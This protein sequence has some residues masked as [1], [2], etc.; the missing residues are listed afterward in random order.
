M[1]P[2]AVDMLR[3]TQA[4]AGHAWSSA[5]S[6]QISIGVAVAGFAL[7]ALGLWLIFR[8]LKVSEAAANAASEATRIA[9]SDMRPWLTL[10]ADH[11]EQAFIRTHDGQPPFISVGITLKVENVGRSPALAVDIESTALIA[12]G[13]DDISNALKALRERPQV[14]FA[15]KFPGNT[16]TKFSVVSRSIDSEMVNSRFPVSVVSLVRYRSFGGAIHE[17]P[18]VLILRE[19]SE[20]GREFGMDNILSPGAERPCDIAYS[21]DYPVSPT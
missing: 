4:S 14:A 17:T 8:Q 18:A 12:A 15:T 7:N 6:A 20:A 2:T 16:T 3:A 19:D 1:D 10:E 13:S 9:S 21:L 11:S 5:L